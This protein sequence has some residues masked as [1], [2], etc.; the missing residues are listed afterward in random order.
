MKKFIKIP[1]IIVAGLIGLIVLAA[2]LIPVFFKDD[3]RKAIDTQLDKNL[4]AKVYYDADKFGISLFRS[5]PNLSVRMQDF[6]LVGV[7]AFEQDTL[8]SVSKF[9]LVLDVMSL[10]GDITVN[11]IKIY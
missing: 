1:L 3:I 2:V 5:F 7:G 8:A 9:E 11:S 10:F 4:N 6:G